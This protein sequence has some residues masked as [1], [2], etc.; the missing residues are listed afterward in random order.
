[1]DYFVAKSYQE[2]QRMGDPYLANGKMYVAVRSPKGTTK[3]VRAYTEKEYL[4]MYP[5]A[6]QSLPI[7]VNA[8]TA[9]PVV[10]NILGFAE[11]FIWIFKGNLDAAD[12]WFSQ[13]VE[14]RY[15][16]LWGWYVASTD[17]IPEDMPCCIESIKLPWDKVGNADG[18][19]LPKDTVQN[20]V[21]GLRFGDSSSE[22]QGQI[23]DRLDLTVTLTRIIDLGENQFG[24][25]SRIFCFV[26][27]A[28]NEYSWTTGV[29]KSWQVNDTLKMR[30]TVKQHDII[31]GHKT[32]LLTRVTEVK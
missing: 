25:T 31:K 4:K 17:T 15:H 1:M 8:Q 18:T 7:G 5:A 16:V 14:C 26:D 28:A 27:A 12:Y 22:F 30:G 3:N 2:W 21:D 29:T 24:S 20:V 19:L 13:S 9:G 11:G 6:T 32:T 10:K 23:G